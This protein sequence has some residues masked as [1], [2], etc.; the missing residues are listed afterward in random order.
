MQP[1]RQVAGSVLRL[2]LTSY[3][4][5]SAFLVIATL[6]LQVVCQYRPVSP[7]DPG[8]VPPADPG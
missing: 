7:G 1:Q 8:M 5:R 6:L 2:Y 3:A 4:V